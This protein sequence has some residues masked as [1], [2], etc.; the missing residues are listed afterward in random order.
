MIEKLELTIAAVTFYG[1]LIA[2]IAMFGIPWS[3][4]DSAY[5]LQQRKQGLEILFSAMCWVVAISMIFVFHEVLQEIW[6]KFVGAIT[7]FGLLL[8][9]TAFG[10]KAKQVSL[11]HYAGAFLCVAGSVIIVSATCPLANLVWL[12]YVVYA[13]IRIGLMR[14]DQLVFTTKIRKTK[15]VTHI[16]IAAITAT[17]IAMYFEYKTRS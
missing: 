2:V 9:G 16:E 15:P 1:Y 12:A 14:K 17:I 3:I 8:V 10:F 13:A 4:S 6:L 7:C 5:L 11:F